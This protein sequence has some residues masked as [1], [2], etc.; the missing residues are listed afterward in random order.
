[1]PIYEYNC[2]KCNETFSV[3]QSINAHESHTL[4]PKCNSKDVEKK[5][6]TFSCCSIGAGGGSSS[7]FGSS[8]GFSRGFGGG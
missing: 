2:K 5:I 6:S 8:G 4:C 1:M 7:P 3:F